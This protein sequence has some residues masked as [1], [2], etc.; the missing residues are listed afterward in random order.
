MFICR[1]REMDGL[2]RLYKSDKFQCVIM[3]GRRRVGKT[4]LI[5]EFIK[6]KDAI[7]FTAQE[8]NAKVT[9]VSYQDF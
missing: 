1:K 2:D 4:A 9:L 6:N 3:Y 8:T 5:S 7:Y